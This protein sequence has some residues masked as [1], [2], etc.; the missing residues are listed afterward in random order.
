MPTIPL[1]HSPAIYTPTHPSFYL[2]GSFTLALD[3]PGIHKWAIIQWKS[4]SNFIGLQLSMWIRLQTIDSVSR[5]REE[6]KWG[7]SES[8][9]MRPQR[10]M[11]L[12]VWCSLCIIYLWAV[13]ASSFNWMWPPPPG[14]SLRQSKVLSLAQVSIKPTVVAYSLFLK[15]ARGSGLWF[16][17]YYYPQ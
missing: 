14:V 2:L 4:S 15:D 5:P 7:A 16:G 17:H 13:S 6:E 1:I 3:V 12:I 10:A 8:A 11:N 9:R